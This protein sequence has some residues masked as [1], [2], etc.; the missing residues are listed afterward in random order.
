M[1][2]FARIPRV[3]LIVDD[4]ADMRLYLRSCIEALRHTQVLEAED[5]LEALHLL[6]KVPVDLVISDVVMPRLDGVALCR[7]LK[8]NAD[9]AA[10]PFVLISGEETEAPLE[11]DA[12]LAKPF[13]AALLQA[14]LGPL[15]N[16]PP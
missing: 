6:R 16:R 9:F 14:C 12:F 3:V 1:A 8:A 2:S 15:L 4:D 10:I 11:A 7:A 5:G 13:N